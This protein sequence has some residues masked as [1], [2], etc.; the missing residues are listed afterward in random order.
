METETLQ[1]EI[2]SLLDQLGWSKNRLAREIY[3]FTH[4]VDEELEI[5]RFEESLRK[6]LRRSTTSAERLKGYLEFIYQ[7]D[8][9]LKTESLKPKYFQSGLLSNKMESGMKSISKRLN[10]I[11]EGANDL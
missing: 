3:V 10:R 5:K 4:D 2:K 9:Y 1:E 7:H 11:I 6:Q 8:E